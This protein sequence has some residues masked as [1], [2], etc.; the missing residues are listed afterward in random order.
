MEPHTP[1]DHKNHGADEPCGCWTGAGETVVCPKCGAAY[2]SAA[3]RQ[4][5]RWHCY[6]CEELVYV[7]KIVQ[8]ARDYPEPGEDDGY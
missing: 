7:E 1:N 6:D 5:G 2:Q 8:R 3:V 4:I